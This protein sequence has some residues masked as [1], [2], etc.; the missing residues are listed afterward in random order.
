MGVFFMKYAVVQVING[1]YSI[2]AE[3]ITDVNQAKVSF[4]GRCQALW[5]APDVITGCIMIVDEYLEC[6]GPYKEIISHPAPEAT[7]E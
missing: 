4:H 5:N 7:E 3:G 2:Y 1:N 6:I